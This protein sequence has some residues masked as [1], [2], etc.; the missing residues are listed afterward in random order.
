MR[1]Q[2]QR[3][4]FAYRIAYYGDGYRSNPASPDSYPLLGEPT[5]ILNNE[6]SQELYDLNTQNDV[7]GKVD[8]EFNDWAWENKK[9]N[10]Y[11]VEGAPGWHGTPRGPIG[12]W[13]HIEDFLKEKY[14]AAHRG[15]TLGME[16]AS[17]LMDVLPHLGPTAKWKKP[18]YNQDDK[19]VN[20]LSHYETGLEAVQKYGY[21]PKEIVAALML[22]HNDSS[23]IRKNKQSEDGVPKFQQ[24]DLDRL[25][26]IA[27]KRY[28][29]Q[30]QYEE[31]NGGRRSP[32]DTT[33]PPDP[34]SR[35][36]RSY[37]CVWC[38]ENTGSK[39]KPICEQCEAGNA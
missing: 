28:L 27:T 35:P 15:L 5:P 24:E 21:D 4:A 33:P 34:P 22:L 31:A 2:R 13:P 20:D 11:D 37:P 16:E 3:E 38:G 23:S 32:R 26:D 36:R 17:W 12:Y 19:Y 30:R 1:I 18:I 8:R 39:D 7:L 14:P 10:P 29:Q 6:D 25:N 9:E